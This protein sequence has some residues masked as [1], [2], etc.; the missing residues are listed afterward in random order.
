MPWEDYSSTAKA[1]AS[2]VP[3]GNPWDD[4]KQSNDVSVKIPLAKESNIAAQRV[5]QA[6]ADQPEIATSKAGIA[7]QLTE[8]VRPPTGELLS[9]IEKKRK[10][11]QGAGSR[12]K[13]VVQKSIGNLAERGLNPLVAGT[14]ATVAELA[15]F[16][17]SEFSLAAGAETAPLISGIGKSTA[18]GIANRYAQT[19]K[20]IREAKLR[21]GEPTVGEDILSEPSVIS[22]DK[23]VAFGKIKQLSETLG[24]KV[25][26][27]IDK[28][29][30]S[31][32][33][34][35]QSMAPFN[36]PRSNPAISTKEIADSIDPVIKSVG[37]SSG[38][39]SPRYQSL[40]RFKEQ[41]L[42]GKPEF[43]DFKT[44]N[45]IRTELGSEVG[46]GFDKMGDDL[47]D[48]V[49]AQRM[50]W[51]KL[52]QKIGQISPEM[53]ELL[54]RQHKLIDISNSLAPE[55]SKGYE[56]IPTSIP[57]MLVSPVSTN[58]RLANFM[59]KAS[60][61]RGGGAVAQGLSRLIDR[62]KNK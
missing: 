4:Y 15:P 61:S 60:E 3:A 55:A 17:P 13:D 54:Q 44:A 41:W 26:G 33:P 50:M 27:L 18:K 36:A 6:V 19:P 8:F 29:T 10:F 24:G 31:G 20:A 21:S 12:V 7:S 53:D 42:S 39:D 34:K 16:S 2:K 22:N 35:D 58:M 46:R 14:M 51:G 32:T 48:R 45:N 9:E 28:I 11:L 49:L 47:A 52:R 57:E 56:K 1:P 40:L 23:G 37:T 43:V 5:S 25:Q 30:K 38:V 59:N 62:Y